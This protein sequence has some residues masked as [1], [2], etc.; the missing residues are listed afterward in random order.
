MKEAF[1]NL[2]ISERGFAQAQ[3]T[4]GMKYVKAH[5]TNQDYAMALKCKQ[6]LKMACLRQKDP[7]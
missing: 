7:S 3:L 1:R 2:K 6:L 5:G 4:L